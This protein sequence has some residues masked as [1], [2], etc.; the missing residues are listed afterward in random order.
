M[1]R[2]VWFCV[3]FLSLL[4]GNV[5]AQE[6]SYHAQRFDVNVMVREDGSLQV[7]E[8]VVFEFA[9]DPFTFVYRELET[10]FTDGIRSIQAAVDGRTLPEGEE[11]G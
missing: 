3:L 10:D 5:A 1:W 11:A 9:G 8:T 6:Q 2:R 4:A 7:T